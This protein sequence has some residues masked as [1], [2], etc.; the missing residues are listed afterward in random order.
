MKYFTRTEKYQKYVNGVPTDEFKEGESIGVFQ[1]GTINECEKD[2][3]QITYNNWVSTS[4]NFLLENNGFTINSLGTGDD[5]LYHFT[6]EGAGTKLRLTSNVIYSHYIDLT[7]M[8]DLSNMALSNSNNYIGG[9]FSG[10]NTSNVTNMSKLFHMASL[11][12][13][14]DLSSFNTSKVTR[15]ESMFK[16]CNSLTEL[17]LSSFNTSKV[18][19]MSYIFAGCSSLTTLDLSSFNTSNVTEMSSMFENCNSITTL[20]LSHFNTSNVTTM[21]SMFK[22]CNSLTALDL[23]SFNTSNVGDMHSIF[24]GCSSLTTLDLSSFNTSNVTFMSGMFSGCSSLTT[25]NLSHFNT[26]NAND[27]TGMF[28][29]CSSLRELN[30]SGFDLTKT[31]TNYRH[32]YMFHNCTSLKTIYAYNCNEKTIECINKNLSDEGLT[33][34]VTIITQ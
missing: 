31:Y 12:T 27:T 11:C 6:I 19:N 21:N 22:S 32:H 33:N 1:F 23:S 28:D 17:N 18:T 7:N 29:C 13:T 4:S 3:P 5:G 34:Q 14:L 2:T 30:I 9:D 20:N 26:S 15:M 10:W 16:E 25:L 8:T 24:D